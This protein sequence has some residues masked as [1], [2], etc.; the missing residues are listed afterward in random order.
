MTPIKVIV[1]GALG[2]MGQE[3]IKAL[4][5]EKKMC[6][7]G[8]VDLKASKTHLA[9][10]NSLGTVPLSNSI[11]AILTKCLPDV[12][13]DFS[14]AKAVIPMARVA[15]KKGIHLVIGTTGFSND[16]LK[17]IDT[18]ARKNNVGVVLAANFALGA[19]MMVYL[20]KIAAR[21]FDFAEIIEQH[22]HLKVDSPSGTALTTAKA[23]AKSR[24][25]RFN[26]PK[27][28]KLS[29]SRGLQVDGIAIHSVRLPGIMARQEVI[30]GSPGQTLSLKHDTVSRECYMPGVIIATSEVLRMKGLTYGLDNLLGL[31]ED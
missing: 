29:G 20:A 24:G 7:V 8:A 5:N 10:P 4:C 19:V 9:L 2:K 21:Y 12:I 30:L 14:V 16:E 17:E 13:I 18:L 6:I 27:E 1:H 3:V 26:K 15:I 31:Q 28:K 22:H 23:M 11:E 25:K